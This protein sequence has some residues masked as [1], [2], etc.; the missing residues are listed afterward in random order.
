MAQPNLEETACSLFVWPH[1]Y[2]ECFASP[3]SLCMRAVLG[4]FSNEMNCS[5]AIETTGLRPQGSETTLNWDHTGLRP[6]W[7]EIKLDWD[8][9]ELRP[10]DWDHIGLR[11]NWI[12]EHLWE[13]KQTKTLY[14]IFLY[15]FLLLYHFV[16]LKCI[17][18][19]YYNHLKREIMIKLIYSVFNSPVFVS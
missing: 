9:S 5:S 19:I 14:F 15:I 8:Q 1:L 3:A 16:V 17:P 18:N 2:V 6:H 7:T 11:P 4:V 10:L 12:E 13:T